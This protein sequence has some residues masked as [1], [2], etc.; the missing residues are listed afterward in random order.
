[1]SSTKPRIILAGIGTKGD[2]FPLLALG[3][4]LVQ[5]GHECHL[6]GNEGVEPLAARHGLGFTPV[7]VEQTDNTVNSRENLEHHILPSY[8]PTIDHFRAQMARAQPLVVVNSSAFCASN[9]LCEK[10]GVPVC[11][12]HLA[13][14]NLRSLKAP[15]WPYREKL[16]GPLA[17]TYRKYFLPALFATLN[18]AQLFIPALNPLRAELGLDPVDTIPEIDRVV[19]ARLGFFPSWYAEPAADWPQ[20]FELA[21]FPL[22]ATIATLPSE[23]TEFVAREGNPIVFTPGTGVPDVAIFFEQARQCCE[24]LDM[25]GVFL[26]RHFRAP[27]GL[28][29][30]ILHFEFLDLELVLKHAALL[31]HHGGIGTTARAFQA[32]VPQII[33]ARMY[34]QPDNGDRVQRL[35]VGRCLYGEDDTTEALIAAT[36]HLITSAE[37]QS[38]VERFRAAIAGSGDG[39]PRAADWVERFLAK[40]GPFPPRFAS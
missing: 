39:I 6:L 14:N 18:R 38:Q 30:R 24:A 20:P 26:S 28:G 37:V 4:E 15:P 7:T 2:L 19:R 9:P 23:F 12:I 29:S 27:K 35:G 10:Y 34:D 8:R 33:R 5:R 36:K 17:A 22:P 21:G 13:P 25:P 3:R 32:G 40:E 16:Q 11:R 1:M 31:V